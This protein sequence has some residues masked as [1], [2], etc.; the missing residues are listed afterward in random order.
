MRS[1]ILVLA[2]AMVM[3]FAASG[4][5]ELVGYWSFDDTLDDS[6]TYANNGI[7]QGAVDS[8]PTYSSDVPTTLGSG[9]S[10]YFQ[11]FLDGA[12]NEA[13][14]VLNSESLQFDQVFTVS[15]W[16]KGTAAELNG[17]IMGK[18]VN[19]RNDREYGFDVRVSSG[20]LQHQFF[21]LNSKT[22]GLE[23]PP[24]V[25][26]WGDKFDTGDQGW[27][28]ATHVTEIRSGVVERDMYINGEYVSTYNNGQIAPDLNGPTDF[29]MG[30][31]NTSDGITGL[32][33]D[34]AIWDE[35]LS[36][37]DLAELGAG[38]K[39]PRSWLPSTG[40]IGDADENGVVNAA[41][42]IAIKAHIGQASGASLADG[43][44]DADGD[45]DWADLQLLQAHYGETSAGSAL[46]EPATLG[47]LAIGAM[48]VI[49]R[50]RS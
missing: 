39:T 20:G 44:F 26:M 43:D 47:L 23:E 18:G 6:S 46:P 8:S 29:W 24:I 15:F 5:G 38:T 22:D 7:F 32:L 9:A 30:G 19:W 28:L 36:A 27:V 17:Y 1:S 49:R 16:V 45:V 2:A 40:L 35:A 31:R 48:A 3:V 34:V 13:V 12:R 14:K 10:I 4:Q 11:E 42:Y 37:E 41:D 50:R 21:S 25:N 33:D